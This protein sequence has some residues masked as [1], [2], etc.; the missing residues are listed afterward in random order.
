MLRTLRR[1][2]GKLCL[3]AVTATAVTVLWLHSEIESQGEQG[4]LHTGRLER[5]VQQLP[6]DEPNLATRTLASQ[7]RDD[8]YKDGRS[9]NGTDTDSRLK[10]F[11]QYGFRVV[12]DG[13]FWSE[14]LEVLVPAGES[15]NDWRR[16]LTSIRNATVLEMYDDA[17]CGD[18][19][20]KKN[21]LIRLSDGNLMCVRYKS[22]C[23]LYGEVLSF[24]LS[25]F[26][27]FHNVPLVTLSHLN[28]EHPNWRN[29]SVQWTMKESG[30]DEDGTVSLMQWLDDATEDVPVP[31]FVKGDIKQL[32]SSDP[33]L[34]QLTRDELTILIQYTDMVI[35]DYL[36]GHYDRLMFHEFHS[37]LNQPTHNALRQGNKLWLIDNETA[38]FFALKLSPAHRLVTM[39]RFLESVCIFRRK[40]VERMRTLASDVDS[41]VEMF[42]NT[43][44]DWEPTFSAMRDTM[45]CRIL[46]NWPL[47]YIDYKQTLRDRIK[48]VYA[49]INNCEKAV[50]S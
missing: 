1:K 6:G 31:P 9:L 41:A 17:P 15:D 26:L 11:S 10:T 8:R 30:W 23:W 28:Q 14:E 16:T 46:K 4:S 50:G 39:R 3:W 19:T 29:P 5:R 43:L 27:G 45:S 36:I 13:I 34:Q 40:T 21:A 24:H 35:F 2:L 22:S 25:R 49:H 33:T 48:D 38:F 42:T 12:E 18:R 32:N 47:L 44:S 20:S 7:I 37:D